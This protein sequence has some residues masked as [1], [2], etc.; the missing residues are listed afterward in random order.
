MNEKEKAKKGLGMAEGAFAILSTIIGGGIV[1][2]PYSLL[3]AGIP[4]GVLLHALVAATCLYSCQLYVKAKDLTP[5]PVESMYEI[6]FILFGRKM[7][8]VIAAIICL[9]STGLMMVYFIVFGDIFA[10]IA[11]QLFFNYDENFFTTRTFYILLLGAGLSFLVVKKHLKEL[12]IISITLFV[13]VGLFML[14]FII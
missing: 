9:A 6:G 11:L 7:I 1:G 5:I 8:Y 2:V 4:V 13:T 14:L 10:S 12:K 3:H